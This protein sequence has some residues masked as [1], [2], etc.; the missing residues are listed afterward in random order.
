[1]LC[2]NDTQIVI[3]PISSPRNLV[4]LVLFL[5]YYEKENYFQLLSG[6]AR[7]HTYLQ[8]SGF[9]NSALGSQHREESLDVIP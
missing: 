2:I 4:R 8:L 3:S 9:K 5:Y 1:M 6:K 7:I